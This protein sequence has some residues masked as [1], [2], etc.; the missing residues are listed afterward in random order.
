MKSERRSLVRGSKLP[1]CHS[2]HT[3]VGD[4][5]RGPSRSRRVRLTALYVMWYSDD[6]VVRKRARI[7]GIYFL[8]FSYSYDSYKKRI[9]VQRSR[10][11]YILGTATAPV[12]ACPQA[13]RGHMYG[14]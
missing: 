1:K 2:A 4:L 9:F 5:W 14:L 8:Q 13:T 7:V 3:S 10:T 12:P 11:T 6:S